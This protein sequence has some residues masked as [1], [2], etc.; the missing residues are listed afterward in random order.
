M[1][2]PTAAWF[3]VLLLASP[4]AI[5]Q[6]TSLDEGSFTLSRDGE[7][8]GR[9]DFSVRSTP[10]SGAPV[11]VAQG[12]LTIGTRRLSP[13]LNADTTGFVLRY[14]NEVRVG[15]RV[16]ET[17]SGVTSRDH[18]SS[19]IQRDDGESAREFRLPP[20]TVA[21]DDE[22][23]HQLWFVARRGAGAVVPVLVP[24]RNLVETVRVELVGAE[25]LTIDVREF[26]TTHLRLRT[27]GTG[28]IRD[29]W[30]DADGHMLK[31]SIPAMKLVAVRDDLR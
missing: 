19:R 10:G 16:T 5:R 7:R 6:V 1:P 31:A 17:Y 27:D 30:M 29:V 11:L 8:V 15:G 13:G 12:R 9:E 20:G 18:Y 21:V 4:P 25:R 26:E 24:R 14:Q 2:P 28:V 22:V 3:A 23:V